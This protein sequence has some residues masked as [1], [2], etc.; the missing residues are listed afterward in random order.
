[1]LADHKNFLIQKKCDELIEVAYDE[2]IQVLEKIRKKAISKSKK[3]NKENLTVINP[4]SKEKGIFKN[5]SKKVIT[6]TFFKKKLDDLWD[7]AIVCEDFEDWDILDKINKRENDI[8]ERIHES[9]QNTFTEHDIEKK[10]IFFSR[11]SDEN[12]NKCPIRKS[13]R[14]SI[15]SEITRIY[16]K[17]NKEFITKINHL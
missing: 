13:L 17:K 12:Y 16:F 7:L 1:M 5:V 11:N 15:L 6:K 10:Y 4:T 9:L 8:K 14:E 2:D 3:H